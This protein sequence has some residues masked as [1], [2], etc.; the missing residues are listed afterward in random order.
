MDYN[1]QM[2]KIRNHR[3]GTDMGIIMVLESDNKP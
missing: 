3:T 1:I 2:S